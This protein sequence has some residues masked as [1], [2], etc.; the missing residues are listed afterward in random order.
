MDWIEGEVLRCPRPKIHGPIVVVMFGP[1]WLEKGMINH[2]YTKADI[3]QHSSDPK[4]T[5]KDPKKQNQT[6]SWW[7]AKERVTGP[8]E[9]KERRESENKE[10]ENIK[11]KNIEK[12]D[13]IENISGHHTYSSKFKP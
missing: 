12:E 7:S 8:G 10:K 9:K 5:Q 3:N 13:R 6:A 1:S 2:Q 11:R 4:K